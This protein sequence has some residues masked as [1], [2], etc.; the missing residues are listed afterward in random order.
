MGIGYTCHTKK[1]RCVELVIIVANN[2]NEQGVEEVV[3][4]FP[5]QI[6]DRIL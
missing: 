2:R 1:A 3:V 6:T 4:Q 5:Q